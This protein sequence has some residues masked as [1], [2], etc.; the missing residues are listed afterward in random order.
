[1]NLA[2][3]KRRVYA[4]LRD[5][6]RAFATDTE[7]E[8]WLNDGYTDVAARLQLLQFE[9]VSVTTTA[10]I[11][12][13][14]GAGDPEPIQVLSLRFGDDDVEWIDD[15]TFNAWVDSDATPPH[16][17]GRYWAGKLELYP[18]P[19]VGTSFTLRYSYLPPV[20][21]SVADV[22]LLPPHLH[23]KLVYYAAAQAKLKYGELDESDRFLV[24]Y[25]QNL[26]PPIRGLV[27]QRPAPLSLIPEPGPFDVDPEAMHV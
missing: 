27:T 7:V 3:L 2:D 15:A 9:K 6:G 26:P 16:T 8:D 17:L 19:A 14:F 23:I 12:V 24:L 4:Q 25:E 5:S 22:P 18:A 21:D 10:T 11:S 13:P 1:M 20:L